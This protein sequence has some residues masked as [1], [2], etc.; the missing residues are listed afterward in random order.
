[1][2]MQLRQQAKDYKTSLG[3]LCPIGKAWMDAAFISR[4]WQ[5]DSALSL[6]SLNTKAMA[7]QVTSFHFDGRI[8]LDSNLQPLVYACE[9]VNEA[10]GLAKYWNVLTPSGYVIVDNGTQK[11]GIGAMYAASAKA[12]GALTYL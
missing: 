11:L 10:L 8:V 2:D 3:E 5:F 4:V 6:Q 7:T 12:T 1:M 9:S